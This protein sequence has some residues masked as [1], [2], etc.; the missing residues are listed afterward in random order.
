MEMLDRP[1]GTRLH[2]R[3]QTAIPLKQARNVQ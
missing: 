3:N 2:V 1:S